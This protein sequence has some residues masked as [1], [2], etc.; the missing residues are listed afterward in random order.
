MYK[1][2]IYQV[3]RSLKDYDCYGN[4]IPKDMLL[5]I[6]RIERSTS[7]ALKPE[8]D[9]TYYWIQAR[10]LLNEDNFKRIF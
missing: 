9:G 6:A 8:G 4:I 10:D 5:Q 7:I 3:Y 1:Y 2:D